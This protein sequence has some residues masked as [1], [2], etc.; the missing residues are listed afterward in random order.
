[1]PEPTRAP[2]IVL[3]VTGSIAAFRAAD[4]ASQLTKAGCIV[5][6]VLTRG[7]ERF[8][9]ALT[10][11]SLTRQPVVTE[12]ADPLREGQ[13]VHIWLADRADLVL[14]A[15]AS[16]NMIAAAAHGFAHDEL[17]CTLLA[18]PSETPVA[19][20]PAMNGKM[21]RHPAVQENVASLK[22]RGVEIIGPAEGLLACGYEGIGRLWP[23][24]EIAARILER[25]PSK[26]DGAD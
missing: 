3:G 17:T 22:A 18:T 19:F 11:S 16:A 2:R 1:M 26:P 7:G 24:D 25:L 6:V 9:T 5:D 20:A 12:A 15:P 13:P 23:V 14:V 4:L 21:W 10:L 8:I